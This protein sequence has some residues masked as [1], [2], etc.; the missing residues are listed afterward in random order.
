MDCGRTG[1]GRRELYQNKPTPNAS[2]YKNKPT[3]NTSA[4]A[5]EGGVAEGYAEL[6]RLI[7]DSTEL[8]RDDKEAVGYFVDCVLRE[9]DH[10]PWRTLRAHRA[11]HAHELFGVRLLSLVLAR[12]EARRLSVVAMIHYVHNYCCADGYFLRSTSQVEELLR[13]FSEMHAAGVTVRGGRL[14]PRFRRRS[15]FRR[16]LIVLAVQLRG[17]GAKAAAVVQQVV[18]DFQP[19]V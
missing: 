13:W 1:D 5:S 3:P 7:A 12:A 17:L 18:H 4:M 6:E 10:V 11:V 9:S 16:S 14:R 19:G 15:R 2:V 8:S